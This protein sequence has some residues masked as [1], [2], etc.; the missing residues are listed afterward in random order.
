MEF[1]LEFL[2][3]FILEFLVEF[4]LEF[5]GFVE[6]II[7]KQEYARGDYTRCRTDI[8]K[9]AGEPPRPGAL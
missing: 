1:F 4:I 5:L 9:R 7:S 3:E 6:R 8:L 2:V